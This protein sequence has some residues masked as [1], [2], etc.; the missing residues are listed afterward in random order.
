MLSDARNH[1][2]V[3]LSEKLDNEIQLLFPEDNP[4]SLL[5]QFF[6]QTFIHLLEPINMW[7]VHIGL[8]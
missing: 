3:V 7:L 2:N 5:L 8:K 4:N 1:S 6:C